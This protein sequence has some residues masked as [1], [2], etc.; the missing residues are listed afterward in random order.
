MS[1]IDFEEVTFTS[2]CKIIRTV[3]TQSFFSALIVYL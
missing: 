1:Y 2:R 3:A